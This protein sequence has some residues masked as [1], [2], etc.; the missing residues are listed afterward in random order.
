MERLQ[1]LEKELKMIKNRTLDLELDLIHKVKQ[2]NMSVNNLVNQNRNELE[3]NLLQRI[4]NYEVQMN[5]TLISVDQENINLK[6][7]IN[8]LET[9]FEKKTNEFETN[10]NTT[11]KNQMKQINS[12][13][14]SSLNETKVSL[15]NIL[16]DLDLK[17]NKKIPNKTISILASQDLLEKF[18]DSTTGIGFDD[19]DGW[20]L[21]NG[22]NDTPDLRGRFLVGLNEHLNDYSLIGKLGGLESVRLSL[23]THT[24]MMDIDIKLI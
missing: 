17:L 19:F 9:D 16:S 6:N 14:A 4:N 3:V 21:C 11:I 5:Q 10:L 22:Q 18:F 7:Q 1:I 13:L 15:E 20:Y 24:W 23:D 12:A 2:Q 8:K